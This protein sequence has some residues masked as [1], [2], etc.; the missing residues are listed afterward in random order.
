MVCR[1]HYLNAYEEDG[2]IHIDCSH[3][4]DPE[5]LS[6]LYLKPMRA[7]ERLITA[8]PVRS[9]LHSTPLLLIISLLSL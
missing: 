1:Y 7:G 5:M 2:K 4:K 6:N 3:H 9:L 8:A